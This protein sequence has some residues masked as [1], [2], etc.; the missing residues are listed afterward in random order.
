MPGGNNGGDDMPG[1]NRD[2]DNMPGADN[3]GDDTTSSGSL[4]EVEMICLVPTEAETTMIKMMAH[5]TIL[6]MTKTTT[7][8]LWRNSS[9]SSVS[10]KKVNPQVLFP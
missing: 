2:E 10:L 3:C 7:T 6:Q 4:A 1:A 9:P 8:I 5:M